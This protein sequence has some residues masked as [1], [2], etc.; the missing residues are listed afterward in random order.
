[1]LALPSVKWQIN[2][3]LIYLWR[4]VLQCLVSLALY[5][6]LFCFMARD[7][8]LIAGGRLSSSSEQWGPKGWG[9]GQWSF[10]TVPERLTDLS[11]CTQSFMF[12][13]EKEAT[14][15]AAKQRRQLEMKQW[16]LQESRALQCGCPRVWAWLA[17]LHLG[18]W[19]RQSGSQQDK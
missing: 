19:N 3:L 13:G 15:A 17:L 4:K 12:T 18:A 5:E 11:Q 10:L 6:K 2:K 16:V 9:T 1:M 8:Q 7:G 14:W